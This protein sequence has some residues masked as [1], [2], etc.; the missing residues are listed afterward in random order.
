MSVCVSLPVQVLSGFHGPAGTF[1][2]PSCLSE[3]YFGNAS[4]FLFS[5]PRVNHGYLSSNDT[6]SAEVK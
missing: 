6:I 1:L 3:Q 4:P 2:L 5:C